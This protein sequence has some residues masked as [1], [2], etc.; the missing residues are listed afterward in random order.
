VKLLIFAGAGTSV[1]L[2]VPA[3]KGMAIE[4]LAHSEQWD[5]EPELVRK[6]MGSNRDLELLIESLDQVCAAREPLQTFVDL[7][8]SLESIETI[9]SEVEW[10]VQHTAERIVARDAHLMWGS[11]LRL[12]TKH[13][14]IFITTNY[15]RAIELAANAEQIKL[16]DG[17]EPFGDNE[18]AS[19]VGF[20][21][22][23]SNPKIVK[24]HGSVDWYAE[25][26]AGS[27][28]KLRH[29]MPLFGRGTLRLPNGKEL[30]TSL[31]LPSREKLLTRPPYPRLTQ[32]FLNAADNCEAAVFV[33]SSL[34]DPHV[35]DAASTFASERLV[36]VVNP[37][38][39]PLGVH[40][41]RTVA[42]SASE[43]LISTLPA[44]LYHSEQLTMIEPSAEVTEL[45]DVD[46]LGKLRIAMDVQEQT[47]RRC[48]AIEYFD[49]RS[50]TL[51]EYLVRKLL[52]DEDE[53][54]SR[55]ALG[56]VA[57]SPSR[58][59]LLVSAAE[60]PHAGNVAF[61]EELAL[62]KRMFNDGKG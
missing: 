58:D 33:G 32:A 38:G 37:K 14:L 46:F 57:T 4:F 7:Q 59:R 29:P 40:Q 18:I 53:T 51:D 56:L 27:P 2:G 43:F 5:V 36:F 9:R 47:Y 23:N 28:V 52:A 39:D 45:K 24:I 6:M 34:R 22:A 62:L 19:W 26:E 60:S 1:E 50:V 12:L 25:Q 61:A 49:Q 8:T 42:Q 16:E 54:V 17:F 48:E 15:D 21:A 3:M 44:A 55:Y 41:A 11:V 30:G 31:V 10:F 13:E 35:R 20:H